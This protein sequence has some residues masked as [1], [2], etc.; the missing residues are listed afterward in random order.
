MKTSTVAFLAA[1]TTCAVVAWGWSEHPRRSR[2][3]SQAPCSDT[4]AVPVVSSKHVLTLEGA[5]QVAAAAVNE[6]RKREAGGAIAVVDDA[7]NLLSFQRTD[8]TFGAGAEVSIG[9]ARTAALFKKPTRAFEE[10]INGGRTALAAVHG[11]TPLQGGVP[12][13]HEGYV[14]GA[15]GVSGARSQAEDEE[16]AIV[17]AAAVASALVGAKP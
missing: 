14:I 3:L 1:F 8:G 5:N 2:L 6:A 12:I 4:P 16:I 11:M 9:K 10:S 15:V 13:V 7:G 17:G